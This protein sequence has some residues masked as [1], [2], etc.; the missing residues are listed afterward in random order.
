MATVEHKAVHVQPCAGSI[1]VSLSLSI[2]FSLLV[3]VIPSMATRRGA[4]A[5]SECGFFPPMVSALQPPQRL[6]FLP[7]C[8]LAR[9]KNLGFG[10]G[11]AWRRAGAA[12]QE[13]RL[14]PRH[15]VPHHVSPYGPSLHRLA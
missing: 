12:G 4:L 6:A 10:G 13:F 9:P 7:S 8:P 14:R 1:S 5:V 2:A 11:V 15:G 3:S